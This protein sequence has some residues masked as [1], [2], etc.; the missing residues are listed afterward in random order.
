MAAPSHLFRIRKRE[1]IQSS[2]PEGLDASWTEYQVLNGR[3]I[4]AR[5][6]TREQAERWI[7]ERDT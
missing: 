6:E 7:A 4:V 5:L 2:R 1:R 3:R